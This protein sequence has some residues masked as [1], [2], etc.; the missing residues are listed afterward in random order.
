MMINV[1]LAVSLV[2]TARLQVAVLQ[3]TNPDILPGRRN[4]QRLDA[5]ERLPVADNPAIRA[6]IAESPA[7]PLA[8]DAR[9]VIMHVTQAHL[10]RRFDW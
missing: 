2:A 10:A 1:L 7:N 4:H 5:L 9:V 3:R 8:P 6:A